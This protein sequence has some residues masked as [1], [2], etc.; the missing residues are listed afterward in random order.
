M[1]CRYCGV[2]FHHKP[3]SR[4]I[5]DD[6][7]TYWLCNIST[8][9]EC[10][11]GNLEIFRADKLEFIPRPGDKSN[12]GI[13][14]LSLVLQ[15]PHKNRPPCSQDVPKDLAKDYIQAS[16]VLPISPE[17]SAALSRRCLQGIL[18]HKGYQQHNLADQIQA[19][20]DS[21][22]LP[23]QV[24]EVLDAVRAIGNFAAHPTK[25][26]VTGEIMEVEPGEAEL[27]IEVIES[28]FDFYFVQEAA[29]K[30]RIAALNARLAEAGKPPIRSS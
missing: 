24:A 16:D 28:L 5:G 2:A 12:S 10:G 6:Q 21:K 7:H 20:L 19:V 17:A 25:R 4:P 18:R 11:N 9:P 3:G 27:N 30:R 23:S 29:N 8:C 26:Q 1:I 13:G 14:P 22:S 15:H